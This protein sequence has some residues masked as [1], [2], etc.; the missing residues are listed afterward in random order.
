MSLK[1][2]RL[3][4]SQSLSST[5]FTATSDVVGTG[6][7][8]LSLGTSTYNSGTDTVDPTSF[9]AKSGV[10]SVDIT[11]DG[12][13][14][15]LAGVRDAIN[16]AD[17]GVNASIINDGSGY[18]LVFEVKTTGAENAFNISVADRR[19]F[20]QYGCEWVSRLAFNTSV[21]NLDQ[22]KAASNASLTINGLAV[23][24]ASNSVADAVEGVTFSLKETTESPVTITVARDTAKAESRFRRF[25]ESVQRAHENTEFLD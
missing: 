2:L 10:S 1:W 16:A 6:T 17:A 4:S 18:R 14:N 21:T 19:R 25:R 15:T 20:K 24:S 23:S 12:T 5:A 13:N 8:T 3:R 9:V 22:T 11:I 7:L